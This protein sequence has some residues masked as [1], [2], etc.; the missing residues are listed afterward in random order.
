MPSPAAIDLA[1]ALPKRTALP[2]RSPIAL[3]LRVSIGALPEPSGANQVRCAPVIAPEIGDGGDHRWPGFGRAMIVGP[4]V[5]ARMEAEV[6]GSVQ[7]RN[8]A[9]T[10]DTS[11]RWCR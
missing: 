4:V 10:R 7:S 3:A 8:A 1:G 5:A 2:S 9:M 11:L 6:S